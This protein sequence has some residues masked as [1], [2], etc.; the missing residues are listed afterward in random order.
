MVELWPPR[1]TVPSSDGVGVV[2]HH[3]VDGPLDG[4]V[5]IAHATGYHG[6]A[7]G[8]LAAV[9]G[10]GHDVWALDSRGHG[11]TPPPPDPLTDWDGFGDD[12]AAAA[13]FV[14]QRAG[15][16]SGGRPGLLGFGHSMGGAA[17]LM[18]AHRDPALFRTLV[19]FEPIVFPMVTDDVD[20]VHDADPAD[21][22]LVLGAR[23]RRARFE[24]YEY[25]IAN[26]ASKP[27]MR[28]FVPAALEA[29]VRG[30]LAP[31]DADDPDGQVRLTCSPEFESA[32]FASSHA[33]NAWDLL[34]AITTPTVVVGGAPADDNP[35][36]A[37]AEPIADRLGSG[38]YC[39]QPEL[40]HFAPFVAP[41]Q[42]AEIIRESAG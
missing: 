25:A 39:F 28:S 1:V 20:D 31:I 17:L 41:A 42:V 24:S 3:L 21:S 26:Y 36:A 37:I 19:L 16:G 11:A 6:L 13:A 9:L 34:P 5:L 8:P 38:R 33:S 27:P 2:L 35:P 23:R 4:P 32:T 10:A 18:A 7:Y 40:D 22:P 12:A 14:Q 29:Y 30:G 15:A